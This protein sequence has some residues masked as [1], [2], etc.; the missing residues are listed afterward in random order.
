MGYQ[1][2]QNFVLILLFFVWILAGTEGKKRKDLT[3]N[4]LLRSVDDFSYNAWLRIK[5]SAKIYRG[6]GFLAVIWFGS[7]PSPVSKAAANWR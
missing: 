7:T 3:I 4:L 6:S 2:I 5:T 1:K